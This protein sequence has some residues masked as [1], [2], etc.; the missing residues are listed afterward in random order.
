MRLSLKR[1]FYILVLPSVVVLLAL[2][3]MVMLPHR[4]VQT[5]VTQIK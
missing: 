3:A 2:M 4:Q 1:K 5:D